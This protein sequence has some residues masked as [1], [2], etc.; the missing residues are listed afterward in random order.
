MVRIPF[1]QVCL[2]RSG[3]VF[4]VKLLSRGDVLTECCF[5]SKEITQKT[6]LDVFDTCVREA[7]QG[8]PVTI[9]VGVR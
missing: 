1:I 6:F 4:W 2:L 8:T 3:H 9:K 7:I 5:S